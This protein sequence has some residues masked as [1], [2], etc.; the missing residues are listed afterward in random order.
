MSW[1]LLNVKMNS[2]AAYHFPWSFGITQSP[3]MTEMT[4]GGERISFH[5][6]QGRYRLLYTRC[7]IKKK[8]KKKIRIG[9]EVRWWEIGAFAVL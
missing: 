2:Y 1:L 5:L 3:E 4:I 9:S 6:H 7:V 8:K